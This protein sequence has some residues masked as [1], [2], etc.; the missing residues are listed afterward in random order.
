[1]GCGSELKKAPKKLNQLKVVESFC[2]AIIAGLAMLG[3]SNMKHPGTK[4]GGLLACRKGERFAWRAIERRP[5]EHRSGV[6]KMMPKMVTEKAEFSWN[7]KTQQFETK[8]F[9]HDQI[10][11]L[12]KLVSFYTTPPN[13][14][15]ESLDD[16]WEAMVDF[17]TDTTNQTVE[18]I[19]LR[20]GIDHQAASLD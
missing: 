2:V 20:L 10:T 8:I 13:L 7:S 4:S 14:F 19:R 1:M 9:V 17:Y 6:Q 16:M 15:K 12:R 3:V 5:R 18:T 11:G